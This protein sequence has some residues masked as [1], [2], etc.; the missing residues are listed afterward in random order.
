MAS[1]D[2][3]LL[4]EVYA[5]GEAKIVGA[6]TRALC[7][8]IR[9]NCKIE[10]IFVENIQDMADAILDVIKDGDVVLCMGAG[11]ISATP[12]NIVNLLKD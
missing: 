8:A 10:P 3:I 4:S 7:R 6:D 1:V 11:S 2:V 12:K 9:L 5:A